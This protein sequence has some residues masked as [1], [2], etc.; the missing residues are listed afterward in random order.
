MKIKVTQIVFLLI[1]WHRRK[2][3]EVSLIKAFV[4]CLTSRKMSLMTFQQSLIIIYFTKLAQDARQQPKTNLSIFFLPTEHLT[5]YFFLIETPSLASTI[6]DRKEDCSFPIPINA[7]YTHT[8]MWGKCQND[9]STEERSDDDGD[10]SER[11][12]TQKKKEKHE[13]TEIIKLTGGWRLAWY[14]FMFSRNVPK[15]PEQI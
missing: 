5:T 15:R 11:K 7:P 2:N 9:I 14:Y 6:H 3:R 13:I 1:L 8:H 12:F 4:I 10:S